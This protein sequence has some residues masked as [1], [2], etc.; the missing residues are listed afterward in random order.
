MPSRRRKQGGAG[1]DGTAEVGCGGGTE[2]AEPDVLA[3][4]QALLEG[5]LEE[6]GATSEGGRLPCRQ[7]AQDGKEDGREARLQPHAAS[8]AA[9]LGQ[10]AQQLQRMRGE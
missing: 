4:V 8:F 9:Y 7:R 10:V 2:A 3:Q 5:E 6:E 1:A